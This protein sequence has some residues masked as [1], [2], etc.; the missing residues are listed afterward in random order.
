MVDSRFS[1]RQSARGK[2]SESTLR[3]GSPR[4]EAESTSMRWPNFF[5]WWQGAIAHILP[6]ALSHD[7]RHSFFLPTLFS[8]DE[9]CNRAHDSELLNFAETAR[10]CAKRS[11][12]RRTNERAPWIDAEILVW[13]ILS[14]SGHINAPFALHLE[15]P[16]C[17]KIDG[18]CT[19]MLRQK[20]RVLDVYGLFDKNLRFRTC[21][22]CSTKIFPH[23]M[24]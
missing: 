17:S 15:G 3:T 1:N 5:L 10:S 9:K 6:V 20:S 2:P 24:F 4:G 16:I 19:D 21:Q 11:R 23:T 8:P 7:C 12:C 22:S 13:N 18:Y 14:P